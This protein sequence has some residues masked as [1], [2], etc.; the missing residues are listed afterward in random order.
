MSY[1]LNPACP[2][3]ENPD[4]AELCQTCGTSLLLGDRY[5]I[6][7]ALGQGGFGATFV[8]EDVSL[9][10]DPKCVIKQ[11]RP[12]ATAPHAF[13][14]ARNLFQREAKTLGKIG[15]HPQIPQLL[16]FF[17]RDKEFYLVQE[18]VDGL[19]LK[20]E[21]KKNGPYSEAAVRQFL[22]EALP[23]LQYVHS[24]KVIH[25]DIKPDNLIRRE[26]DKRL[27]LIDFGAVKDQVQTG[28]SSD[29]TALT[30]V[31]V[32]TPGYAPPEQLSLRPVYASDIYALGA[33]CIYLLTGRSPKDLDYHPTTGEMMWQK[34]VHISA[35]LANVLK[36]MLEIAVKNRY[37]RSEDILR[38]LDLEP[39]MEDLA[40]SMASPV[41]NEPT[42]PSMGGNFGGAPVSNNTSRLA[43]SIRSRRSRPEMTGGLSTGG[44]LSNIS[45]GSGRVSGGNKAK[46]GGPMPWLKGN[47]VQTY[48]AKGRRDFAAHNIS[49]GELPNVNLSGCIFRESKLDKTNLQ[50]SNL[51]EANFAKASLLEANLRGAQLI[52]AY[53]HTANVAK[54]DFRK[55]DLSYANFTNA[56]L[57]GAN[58]C[59]ANLTGAKI[60]EDQLAVAKTN[61]MTIMPSGKR[62][63]L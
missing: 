10:G 28:P 48:Y 39:Y 55:A 61:W 44:S 36:K 58:F 45:G 47:E 42:R 35:H 63:F 18:F 54:A 14:M 13:E 22:S 25:R 12:A 46:A 1:C 30:A 34:Y 33:T 4:D 5:R 21:V 51:T 17:E 26:Q 20:G 52:R 6:L 7:R 27:V 29:Q 49:R 37:Q 56:N 40:Q 3:P 24:N 59:G 57:A 32:G 15:N 2:H 60:D 23:I 62:G 8:A 50:G 41:S 38:A 43:Q 53:F 31:S 19:T 16:N 9:P 11:L